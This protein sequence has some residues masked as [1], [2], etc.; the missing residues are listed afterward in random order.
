MTTLLLIRHGQTDWNLEGR[1]S[2]QSDVPLNET[3]HKQAQN[4]AERLRGE[5]IDAFYSSD[6]VRAYKT[7]ETIAQAHNLPVHTER[8]LREIN[9][10]EWEG[11]L[12]A[13]IR[14]RF[15]REFERRAA[16]PLDVAPPGGETVGEVKQRVLAALDDIVNEHPDGRVLIASHGLALAIIKA[17]VADRPIEEVWDLIP[18][19]ADVE[20]LEIPPRSE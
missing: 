2:G 15:A 19:N 6:L 1:Y 12:F 14:A 16:N 11:M 20:V 10:G 8:R 7:A 4:V 13:D 17:H 9:Q 3:G 18:A 5:R